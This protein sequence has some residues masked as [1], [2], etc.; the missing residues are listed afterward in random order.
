MKLKIFAEM[1]AYLTN[2]DIS[3]F[4]Q[5]QIFLILLHFLCDLIFCFVCF[6]FYFFS[7]SIFLF[8]TRLYYVSLAG[9]QFIEQ[10]ALEFIETHFPLPSECGSKGV[11]HCY[12]PGCDFNFDP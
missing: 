11:S 8:K 9:L 2:C 7:S 5:F 10:A 4:T 12:F 6:F 1:L 3:V